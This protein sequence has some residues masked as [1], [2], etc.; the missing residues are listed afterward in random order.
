MSSPLAS[1]LLDVV[2][3]PRLRSSLESLEAMRSYQKERISLGAATNLINAIIG[4]G[5]LTLPLVISRCGIGLGFFLMCCFAFQT[6][7]V[8]GIL[9]ECCDFTGSRTYAQMAKEL[10]GDKAE[11]FIDIVMIVYPSGVGTSYLLVLGNEVKIIFDLMQQEQGINLPYAWMESRGFLLTALTW[12]VVF[13]LALLKNMKSL[14]YTSFLALLCALYVTSSVVVQP[15]VQAATNVCELAEKSSYTCDTGKCIVASQVWLASYSD[16]TS[17]EMG[18]EGAEGPEVSSVVWASFGAGLWQ[19]LPLLTFTFNCVVQF[20]PI[21]AEMK[22]PQSIRVRDTLASAVLFCFV[23]YT[24]IAMAGYLSFCDR[25]CPNI[26]DCYPA[27]N[28]MILYAR[29]ALVL[30]LLFSFPLASYNVRLSFNKRLGLTTVT[31][32]LVTFALVAFANVVAVQF[33]DLAVIL[34]LNGAIGGSILVQIFPG[35][36]ALEMC[37]QGNYEK[38]GKQ[39]DPFENGTHSPYRTSQHTRSRKIGGIV[40]I[41]VGNTLLMVSTYHILFAASH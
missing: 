35:F 2:G 1:P 16:L 12:I 25:S 20:I 24:V 18:C 27:N 23:V 15:R 9:R 40:L 22:R 28:R 34:G 38:L 17:C 14:Q 7:Y 8:T 3:K 13:P 10:F 11:W 31:H 36:C 37:K 21:F 29:I 41:C 26:L 5:I 30:I 33:K 39:T 6:V 19:S 32:F 4:A